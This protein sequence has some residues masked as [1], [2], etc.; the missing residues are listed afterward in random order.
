MHFAPPPCAVRPPGD[1]HPRHLR[2]HR[3]G[4]HRRKMLS[5]MIEQ[6]LM[7]ELTGM[8]RNRIYEYTAYLELLNREVG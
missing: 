4:P 5:A 3:P 8:R 6:G 7:R 2:H 1:D